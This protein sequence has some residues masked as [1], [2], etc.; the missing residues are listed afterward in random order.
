MYLP[1]AQ[2]PHAPAGFLATRDGK[3]VVGQ[4][5]ICRGNLALP[6]CK[7][8]DGGRLVGSN[9]KNKRSMLA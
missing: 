9:L 1:H 4:G 8:K 2:P 6:A 7:E 3:L 5:S